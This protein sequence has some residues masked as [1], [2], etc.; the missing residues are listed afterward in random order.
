MSA[1]R[2]PVGSPS[3]RKRTCLDRGR[4]RT[5]FLDEPHRPSIPHAARCADPYELYGMLTGSA[6]LDRHGIVTR[7]EDGDDDDLGL[8]TVPLKQKFGMNL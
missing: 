8:V 4:D 6:A 3:S 5:G 1:G 7:E 2:R